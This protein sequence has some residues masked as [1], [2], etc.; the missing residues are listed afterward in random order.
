MSSIG[1]ASNGTAI[2]PNDSDELAQTTRGIW[3]GTAGNLR[4]TLYNGDDVT[5]KSIQAGTLL[6]LGAKKVW[7]TDTTA[8]DLV[9]LW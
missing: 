3:V 8:A 1:P 6:P 9:G 4:V 7:S 2:T 5:L